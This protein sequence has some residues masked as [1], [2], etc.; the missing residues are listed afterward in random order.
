MKTGDTTD[1]QSSTLPVR[2]RRWHNRSSSA[3]RTSRTSWTLLHDPKRRQR[4][5]FS[6]TIDGDMTDDDDDE[7]YTSH[8]IGPLMMLLITLNQF[9]NIH[10]PYIVIVDRQCW[11][12]AVHHIGW[13]SSTISI[14]IPWGWSPSLSHS[15]SPIPGWNLCEMVSPPLDW[16]GIAV[17]VADSGFAVTRSIHCP[18]KHWQSRL[19]HHSIGCA[20]TDSVVLCGGITAQH[21][22]VGH[23][24]ARD[25]KK[26]RFKHASC[27]RQSQAISCVHTHMIVSN[28]CEHNDV[29]HIAIISHYV[30]LLCLAL[31][32]FCCK[33]LFSDNYWSVD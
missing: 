20:H 30:N 17:G 5:E 25:D 11:W 24:M 4:D 3:A 2:R 27:Q 33:M 32:W 29:L 28:E 21:I 18:R 14:I 6:K 10:N 12:C 7:L 19:S 31:Q 1:L 23:I 16:C 9:I 15:T 8:N 13:S 26:Q 22:A